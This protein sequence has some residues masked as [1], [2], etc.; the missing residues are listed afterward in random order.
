MTPVVDDT[1]LL[2]LPFKTFILPLPFQ[3]N[4]QEADWHLF[5]YHE[6][7]NSLEEW[8]HQSLDSLRPTSAGS[9]F[10]QRLPWFPQSLFLFMLPVFFC[11]WKICNLWVGK[12][13]L[14]FNQSL[15]FFPKRT[16]IALI[17]R[18]IGEQMQ[19]SNAVHVASWANIV[20]AFLVHL[21][22][23]HTAATKDNSTKAGELC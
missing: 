13:C 22:H 21:S 16:F 7:W 20:L 15:A 3:C 10:V 11:F 23:F 6:K 2:I 5:P 12:P 17:V 1:N 8:G 14:I 18:V 19:W 4:L 9:R